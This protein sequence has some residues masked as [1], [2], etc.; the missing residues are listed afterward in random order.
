MPGPLEQ[1]YPAA[2]T[3]TASVAAMTGPTPSIAGTPRPSSSGRQDSDER[4]FSQARQQ[5]EGRVVLAGEEQEQ[6]RT[7]REQ[8]WNVLTDPTVINYT[9]YSVGLGFDAK[10]REGPDRQF[11]MA[12]S[13]VLIGVD[14]FVHVGQELG[15]QV[16]N[17]RAD[18]PVEYEK[19]GRSVVDSSRFFLQIAGPVQ[20]IRSI[21][22]DNPNPAVVELDRASAVQ[23]GYWGYAATAASLTSFTLAVRDRMAPARAD[24]TFLQRAGQAFGQALKDPE[25]RSKF[26]DAIALAIDAEAR[27]QQNPPLIVLGAAVQLGHYAIAAAQ[28][29]YQR[30][31]E[32]PESTLQRVGTVAAKGTMFGAFVGTTART[33]LSVDQNNLNPLTTVANRANLRKAWM[34]SATAAAAAVVTTVDAAVRAWRR[35]APDPRQTNA[36]NSSDTELRQLPAP[37]APTT[38]Q[39]DPPAAGQA[40]VAAELRLSGSPRGPVEQ[41][42]TGS[43]TPVPVVRST[44]SPPPGRGT[45]R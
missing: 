14:G 5:E 15:N 42:R 25:A 10:G 44:P 18:N 37:P 29:E 32:G 34:F 20:T 41:G 9:G 13:A 1:P 31:G 33:W 40:V 11:L 7:I 26:V 24:T 16:R 28:A 6:L 3:P 19:L 22:P 38:R 17:L 12:G 27:R 35:P 4:P 45:P 30:R 43:A 8:V 39:P 36:P 23:A 21:N 2:G